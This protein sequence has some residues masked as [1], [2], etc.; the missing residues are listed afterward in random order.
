MKLSKKLIIGLLISETFLTPMA[1]A[2]QNSLGTVKQNFEKLSQQNP[3][4]LQMW[5]NVRPQYSRQ[6][7]SLIDA[8][9][10]LKNNGQGKNKNVS[11]MALKSSQG[12]KDL[13]AII[14]T[15][16][17]TRFFD[18]K[19]NNNDEL[20]INKMNTE[21]LEVYNVD[22]L[23]RNLSSGTFNKE[24]L[25]SQTQQELSAD[26]LTM[27]S[28]NEQIVYLLQ[29]RK[30][31]ELSR[32]V[33]SQK[34]TARLNPKFYLFFAPE[35]AFAA[36]GSKCFNSLGYIATVDSSGNCPNTILSSS[37]YSNITCSSGQLCNPSY[38][39]LSRTQSGQGVCLSSSDISKGKTCSDLAPLK[40]KED[41]R[42]LMSSLMKSGARPEK[43]QDGKSPLSDFLEQAQ[44]SCE[45]SNLQASESCKELMNRKT[46]M[47]G[48]MVEAK[49]RK[50]RPTKEEPAMSDRE[51]SSYAS[52][53][54]TKE[55]NSCGFFCS[56]GRWLTS[57]TGIA[58]M[59]TVAG[60]A[61][62]YFWARS[63]YKKSSSTTTA[64]AST[65]TTDTTVTTTGTYNEYGLPTTPT[66]SDYTGVAQ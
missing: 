37:Q 9:V 63:K 7:Q 1:F 23:V 46:V 66:T 28:N 27:L 22:Q 45:E 61:A 16:A 32:K 56:T 62:G 12:S 19:I 25:L 57:S 3:T 26:E 31:L 42:S 43:P 29:Q 48:M 44:R 39:G 58:S 20:S 36:T 60:V 50:Q 33:L 18:F 21:E 17:G 53:S 38:Y 55:D 6:E 35:M 14:D 34:K 51:A 49:G 40:T 24:V 15:S 4:Y 11:T 65:V 30:L 64:T 10:L 5:L 2:E 54:S 47:N 13:R 8:W 52:S 41:V 59:L